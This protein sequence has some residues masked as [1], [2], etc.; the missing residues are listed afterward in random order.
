[1]T[2]QT[3]F[4]L[5]NDENAWLLVQ[6]SEGKTVFFRRF[7]N[8]ME[9]LNELSKFIKNQCEKPRIYIKSSGSAALSLLKYLCGIPDIEV[10]FVSQAGFKQYQTCL[11]KSIAGNSKETFCEAEILANCA[12]RMI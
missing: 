10:M 6:R 5:D 9:G 12:E 1:M 11:P 8:T 4:G 2:P 7:N 3:Y